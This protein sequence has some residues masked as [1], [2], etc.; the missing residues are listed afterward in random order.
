M[1]LLIAKNG[2]VPGRV[3]KYKAGKGAN[4]QAKLFVWWCTLSPEQLESR[5]Q[6]RDPNGSVHSADDCRT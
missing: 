6:G 3:M 4:R 1:R 5:P 2:G